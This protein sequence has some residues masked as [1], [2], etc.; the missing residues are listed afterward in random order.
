M[1]AVSSPSVCACDGSALRK[2]ALEAAPCC[3]RHAAIAVLLSPCCCRRAAVTASGVAALRAALSW[4][5]VAAARCAPQEEDGG[6]GD[7]EQDGELDGDGAP[8]PR[9]RGRKSK[10]P[11][12]Y[13]T[14]LGQLL[15][16]DG[17]MMPK[18]AL[19]KLKERFNPL[20]VEDKQVTTKFGAMKQAAR[21]KMQLDD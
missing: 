19:R 11:A 1:H 13:R 5:A 14:Y 2:S 12:E 4:L 20:T 6:G 8:S 18:V 3:C 9:K 7:G 17:A 21:K 10:L 15:A 16:D